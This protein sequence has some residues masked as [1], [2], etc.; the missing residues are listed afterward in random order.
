MNAEISGI[1]DLLKDSNFNIETK[2]AVRAEDLQIYLREA[3]PNI[4]H[5]CGHGAGHKGIILIDYN[6]NSSLINTEALKNLFKLFEDTI[7]CVVLNTGNSETTASAI[8]QHIDYFNFIINN[9]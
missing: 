5:C 3:E 6:N 8:A 2:G 4:V 1:K 7:Q 9:L